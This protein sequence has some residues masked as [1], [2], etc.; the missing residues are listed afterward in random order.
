MNRKISILVMMLLITSSTITLA[1]WDPED[2]H[3]MHYPQLPDPNGWDVYATAGLDDFPQIVLADDWGCSET[4]WV[5]DI[6][7]WGSWYN[8]HEGIIDHF[9][10]GVAANIPA[11]VDNIPYSRPGET[12]KEWVIYD[13]DVRGPLNGDQGFYFPYVPEAFWHDHTKYYQYNVFLNEE[14][15][16]WQEEGTIYWLFI[17]AI[18]EFD[19]TGAQ[20]FWGWKS[21][22]NH[23]ED[24][25]CWA[26]W[27]I[28]DW[29]DLWEPEP[30]L[31][32][33][34]GFGVQ[35]M[36]NVV[37][38]FWA[39]NFYGNGFYYYPNTNW[40]NIWFYDHPLDYDRYKE[41]HV[42]FI[43]IPI[44]PGISWA[45]VVVNW[46]TDVWEPGGPPPLPPLSPPEEQMFIGRSPVEEEITQGGFY[47]FDF[48]IPDYNPE[49]VSIDI[50]G[51]FFILDNGI[52]IHECLPD[53]PPQSLDLA[54]V[55][56]G[57]PELP[58]VDVEK[59][60]WDEANADWVEG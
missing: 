37:A 20:P 45:N 40:W 13:W 36:D 35:M 49:W 51:E 33:Q 7:F 3:K 38:D 10:M 25:A 9:V 17:S 6:H 52:I 53:D 18:V 50:R 26:E 29:V 57:E 16:F 2:G 42:E 54:F 11:G 8:D 44:E 12:L 41:I 58:C 24:D 47:F 43:F 46:A 15:W 34:N 30:E 23:W 39:D 56:T 32:V 22:N 59:K 55:I 19:P 48:V 28:L 21:S 14:D 31:I 60:V 1:H 4:G 27:N 5:K